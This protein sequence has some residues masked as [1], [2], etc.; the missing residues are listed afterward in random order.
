MA[1]P[2]VSELGQYFDFGD[3]TIPDVQ[4]IVSQ[5]ERAAQPGVG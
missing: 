1:T 2:N 5:E 3:V 4:E